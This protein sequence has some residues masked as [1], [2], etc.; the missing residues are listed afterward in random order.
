MHVATVIGST[1]FE[2][3]ERGVSFD[4]DGEIL[5]TP[6]EMPS[7]PTARFVEQDLIDDAFADEAEA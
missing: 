4:A 3:M 6:A 2:D 7:L 5:L 1:S